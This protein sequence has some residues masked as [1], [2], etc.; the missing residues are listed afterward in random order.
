MESL[1]GETGE[2][3]QLSE[4]TLI[5]EI[6]RLRATL[7]SPDSPGEWQTLASLQTRL[8]LLLQQAGSPAEARA[9]FRAA[10]QAVPEA[11][12]HGPLV[13]GQVLRNLGVLEREVGNPD[14]ARPH[15]EQAL[16]LFERAQSAEFLGLTL[17]DLGLLDKDQDRLPEA[18]ARLE[19]ATQV[20]Q[21]EDEP[22]NLGHA[23]VGLGLVWE[24]FN[25][26][27][28]ARACYGG[29]LEAYRKADDR[30]NEAVVLHNLGVLF[31]E[32]ERNAEAL[33][34]Y[35]QSLRINRD[36]GSHAGQ[37]DDLARIA[38]IL[39][40]IG[41]TDAA[42]RLQ[43]S[44]LDPAEATGAAL[45]RLDT[46]VN[47]AVLDR[48]RK[49]F[50]AADA[51]LRAAQVLAEALRAPH[52]LYEVGLIRGDT[53]LLA[54]DPASAAVYYGTAADAAERIRA[55]LA[56]EREHLD[57][58]NRPRLEVY[59][60][61]VLLY[62][63]RT[64]DP[65]LA[66]RWVERARGRGLLTRLRLSDLGDGGRVPDLLG[67]REAEL[68]AELSTLDAARDSSGGLESLARWRHLEGQLQEVWDEL[69]RSN[70]EY[71]SLR[72]GSPATWPEL[73]DLLRP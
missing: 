25:R 57:Y 43:E 27:D 30:L 15:F 52:H 34:C 54:G 9:A 11:A 67:E 58:F 28:T 14:E 46:L 71:V 10:L 60:R 53:S 33:D 19:R 22:A 61:L 7:A 55:G 48:D 59:E 12:L 13:R 29:A 32:E 16:A 63:Q 3:G 68:L 73:L 6:D 2:D 36:I 62:T 40:E 39:Q 18:R 20:L 35:R 42:Y 65:A 41:Q 45:A 17:V 4:G 44:I 47:L 21:D 26:R 64:P 56:Q 5:A 38:G 23:L 8:G 69:E 37:L 70:P 24:R 66:L 31:E 1:P 50:A 49:D 51:R 72:R